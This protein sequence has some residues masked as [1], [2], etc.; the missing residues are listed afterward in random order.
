MKWIF[1]TFILILISVSVIYAQN[2]SS[3][4][5]FAS[6]I[7]NVQDASTVKAVS[8]ASVTIFSKVDSAQKQ[9]LITDKNG[10]FNFK[11][12][13]YGFYKL[14]ITFTGYANY[15]VDSVWLHAEKEELVFNDIQLNV[16]SNTLDEV[17]VYSEKKLF[18]DKNGTLTYNVSESPIAN[19]A[20]TADMMKNVP[21]VNTNPDGS[22]TVKGKPPLILIDEK[23]TNLNAQQLSDLLESLPANVIEKVEVMQTPPPEYAT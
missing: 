5:S 13:S 1:T 2:N 6:V 22:L 11:N 4:K 14:K 17:V 10:L 8:G 16:T 7:G 20:S 9:T 15:T 21:L 12:L 23:P 19:G 18:E 3:K